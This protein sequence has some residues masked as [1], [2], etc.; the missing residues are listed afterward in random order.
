MNPKI[1]FGTYRITSEDNLHIEAL[2]RAVEYGVC[3]IDTS[4]NYMNTTSESAIYELLQRLDDKNIDNLKIISKAGYI[5]GTLLNE[6]KNKNKVY[7][8]V[9]E[10]QDN[11]W[12]CIDPWFISDQLASTL[13]R[14]EVKSIEAYLLHNPEY[15]LLDEIS[16]GTS[17]I[18]RLDEMYERIL[19]AF[20]ALEGFVKEGKINSY[21]ISSNSFALEQNNDAFLPY[22]D[23]CDIAQSAAQSVGVEHNNFK[24]IQ[25]P[26]NLL[27]KQAKSAL[28]WA[29]E[30]NLNTMVNRV[31]NAQYNKQMYRL[32]KYEEPRD[33]YKYLNLFLEME[34][35]KELENVI[36]LVRS[37]DEHKHRFSFVGDIEAFVN[38]QVLPSLKTIISKLSDDEK[39]MIIDSLLIFLE[40]YTHMV[41]FESY[42]AT[43][44]TLAQFFKDCDKTLQECALKF[45][46][47]D[48]DVDIVLLG[49]RKV[50]YVEEVNAFNL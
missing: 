27:E 22:E 15:F 30:N 35:S 18:E 49:M 16:K 19:K 43:S 38:T 6:F 17:R 11:L 10:Y 50:S 26:Y 28:S 23:L 1:G 25:V 44:Q 45:V 12:H 20:I 21:G 5:Q 3:Y 4:T 33:Y 40:I 29:K 14:L 47:D 9:V 36:N 34:G 37:L 31:F 24:Y 42:L 41:A 8:D 2:K 46:L 13:Q 48:A 32:C 7:E 39:S